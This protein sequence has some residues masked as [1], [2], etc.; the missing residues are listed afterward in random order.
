MDM[1]LQCLSEHVMLTLKISS[2]P[3]S[4]SLKVISTTRDVSYPHNKMLTYIRDVRYM[5][6]NSLS[7]SGYT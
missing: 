7:T 1:F 4:W 2:L 6:F 3:D 5:Q